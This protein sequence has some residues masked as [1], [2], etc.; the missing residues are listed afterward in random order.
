MVD[1][2]FDLNIAFRVPLDVKGAVHRFLSHLTVHVAA[3]IEGKQETFGLDAKT[4]RTT[5]DASQRC[6]FSKTFT[7]KDK[8]RQLMTKEAYYIIWKKECHLGI[9]DI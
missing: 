7:D 1:E 9:N 3:C 8:F 4:A 5:Q 2:L 6:F